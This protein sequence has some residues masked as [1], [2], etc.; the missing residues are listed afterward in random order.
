MRMMR[1][2]SAGQLAQDDLREWNKNEREVRN[3]LEN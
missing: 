1:V 2:F 3:G